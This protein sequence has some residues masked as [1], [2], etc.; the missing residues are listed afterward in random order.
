MYEAFNRDRDLLGPGQFCEV[1]YEELVANPIDQMRRV[2]DELGLDGFDS[3]RPGIEAYFAG[4]KDYK[5][6]RFQMTP[7]M[8]AE[9]TRRWDKFFKQYG[10]AQ[11]GASA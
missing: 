1:R 11:D 3:V 4:Q 8:R 6:N 9:I 2:Y 7:E 10:Y 5:R